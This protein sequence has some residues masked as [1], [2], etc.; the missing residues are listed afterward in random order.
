MRCTYKVVRITPESDIAQHGGNV[1]VVPKADSCTAALAPCAPKMH[2]RLI[3]DW[4]C[5]LGVKQ[6]VQTTWTDGQ[7]TDP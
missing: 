6:V 5:T 2:R 4:G 3:V 7:R 1:R